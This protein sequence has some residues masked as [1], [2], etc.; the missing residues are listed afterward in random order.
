M[1]SFTVIKGSQNENTT[2]A[3]E[4]FSF[5]VFKGSENGQIIK[6]TTT[7]QIRPNEVLVK[8]LHSGL[9]G[10]DE[11]KIHQDMGLGHEG[12]GVVEV[13]TPADVVPKS[14]RFIQLYILTPTRKL[15]GM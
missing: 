11:H 12:S 10:T 13:S 2:Q 6:S 15:A 14:Q 4:S 5:T 8:V 3:L 1:V 7:R 9:C